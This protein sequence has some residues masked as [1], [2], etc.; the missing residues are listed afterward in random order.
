MGILSYIIQ[1]PMFLLGSVKEKTCHMSLPNVYM[2]QLILWV[3]KDLQDTSMVIDQN[4][5]P[6]VN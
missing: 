2:S 4:L 6:L 1:E 3:G 5:Y